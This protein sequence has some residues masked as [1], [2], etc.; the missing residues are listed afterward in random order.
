M[1]ARSYMCRFFDIGPIS[2]DASGWR[3]GDSFH[4]YI[5]PSAGMYQS[6]R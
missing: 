5:K 1:P 3:E 2:A 6:R 4:L